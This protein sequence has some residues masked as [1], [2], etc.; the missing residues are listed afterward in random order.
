MFFVLQKRWHRL[1]EEKVSGRVP[2]AE[3]W[4]KGWSGL[5]SANHSTSTRY[6]FQISAEMHRRFRDGSASD[7]RRVRRDNNS[8]SFETEQDQIP[9]KSK[10]WTWK[11][12]TTQHKATTDDAKKE[13]KS[14]IQ[15]NPWHRSF[16]RQDFDNCLRPVALLSEGEHRRLWRFIMELQPVW[17]W[18]DYQTISRLRVVQSAWLSETLETNINVEYCIQNHVCTFVHSHSFHRCHTSG[19]LPQAGES[20]AA[21]VGQ[22]SKDWSD[23]SYSQGQTAKWVFSVKL[24][25]FQKM[26]VNF[27]VFRVTSQKCIQCVNHYLLVP[28]S[29]WLGRTFGFRQPFWLQ[30]NRA[31]KR[32]RRMWRHQRKAVKV[33]SWGRHDRQVLKYTS[34]KIG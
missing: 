10:Q 34:M 17:E 1:Q 18:V 7:W 24:L 22:R 28:S 11:R 29:H 12:N 19:P 21:K 30:Q 20:K 23:C 8:N 13:L 31:A 4:C 3:A 6:F 14:T 16:L 2:F 33:S 5:N 25:E 26:W 9:N 27:A 32:S 15:K